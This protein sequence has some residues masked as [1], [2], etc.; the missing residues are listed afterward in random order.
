MGLHSNFAKVANL[1]EL[2]VISR[3]RGWQY[4]GTLTFAQPV[5]GLALSRKL[6][7]GFSLSGSR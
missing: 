1:G 6:V 3:F 7:F 2:D 5:P 4:F